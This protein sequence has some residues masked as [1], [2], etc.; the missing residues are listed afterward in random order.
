ML[1]CAVTRGTWRINTNSFMLC[2]GRESKFLST[3]LDSILNCLRG[4]DAQRG[5]KI[6]NLLFDLNNKHSDSGEMQAR[7]GRDNHKRF[8][9][10]VVVLC[11]LL[12]Y[13][14]SQI[15]FFW[16]DIFLQLTFHLK[17]LQPRPAPPGRGGRVLLSMF[18]EAAVSGV[19][20]RCVPCI[21]AGLRCCAGRAWCGLC[22]CCCTQY[23]L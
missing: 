3:K 17:I 14:L 10:L 21:R 6:W 5:S 7:R 15:Y 2:G 16:S 13:I 12:F 20:P 8:S 18:I 22:C 19:T 23:S 1:C 9:F 11:C 4:A